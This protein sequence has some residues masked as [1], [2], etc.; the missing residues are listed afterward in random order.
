VLHVSVI[1][2]WKYNCIIIV[3]NFLVV[4]VFLKSTVNCATDWKLNVCVNVK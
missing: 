2:F 3:I 4:E 1:E